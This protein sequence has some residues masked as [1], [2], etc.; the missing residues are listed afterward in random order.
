MNSPA[1]TGH[2][3]RIYGFT[4]FSPRTQ[5][6]PAV[7]TSEIGLILNG[8]RG[9]DHAEAQRG[10]FTA[11]THSRAICDEIGERL[12]TIL[13]PDVSEL[14]PRLLALIEKLVQLE[15]DDVPYVRA[16]PTAPS[17]E[18][19]CFGETARS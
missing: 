11:H 7:Y 4:Y 8:R 5:Q 16:P 3:Q 10:R 6:F 14:P 12:R 19:M 17:L 1:R 9:T 2:W 15:I 13:K 18:D